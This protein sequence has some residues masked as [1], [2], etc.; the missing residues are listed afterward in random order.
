[1][2]KHLYFEKFYFLRFQ[3]LEANCNL[4][5][6]YWT[7]GLGHLFHYICEIKYQ[8]CFSNLIK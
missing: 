6:V 7:F 8:R 2:I 4:F 3:S 1:M 5:I